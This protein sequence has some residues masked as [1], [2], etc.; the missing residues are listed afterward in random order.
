[1]GFLDPQ[2][3]IADYDEQIAAGLST[4]ISRTQQGIYGDILEAFFDERISTGD[5]NTTADKQRMQFASVTYNKTTGEVSAVA[6][7]RQGRE[8][9][10]KE[11]IAA[12][13]EELERLQSF[14]NDDY[15]DDA[16]LLWKHK[17]KGTDRIYTFA[18]LKAGGKWHITG[19]RM[20]RL[21]W[22]ELV[23]F[24]SDGVVLEM[25]EVSTW[26]RVI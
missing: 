17:F 14:G 24:W 20:N 11:R 4:E 2:D 18:V 1:M 10:V 5:M 15:Q 8:E 12:Y 13:E 22:D 21:T 7:G 26:E 3:G 6:V 19:N 23:K 25:W 9:F 16:V